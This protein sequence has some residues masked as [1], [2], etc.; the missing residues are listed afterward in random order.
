MIIEKEKV[1]FENAN[2][3]NGYGNIL[4]D[5]FTPMPKNPVIAKFFKEIGLADELGSGVRN[6]F[7]YTNIYSNGKT[8][9]LIEGDIF[10]I[11]IPLPQENKESVGVNKE[12]V[13]VNNCTISKNTQ[14]HIEQQLSGV[15]KQYVKDRLLTIIK[16]I[17]QFE[18]KRIPFYIEKLKL[19]QD[20]RTVER[21][22]EILK[23]RRAYRFFR[24]S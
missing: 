15:K 4:P 17:C 2:K 16:A 9:S 23:K 14:Q 11:I 24:L 18:G 20:E 7:N 5:N 6:L 22:M 19:K 1:T 21:Y 13:G 3:P 12:S 10:K 8:P